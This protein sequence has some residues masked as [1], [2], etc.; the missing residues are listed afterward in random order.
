M[1][2]ITQRSYW[3]IFRYLSYCRLCCVLTS[4]SHTFTTVSSSVLLCHTISCPPPPPF[5][6]TWWT[7]RTSWSTWPGC[8]TS[9]Y[10][11]QASMSW[12]RGKSPSLTPSSSPP[13]P[14]WSTPHMSLCPSTYAWHWSFS[15][16]FA[17]ASLRA[18]WHSWTKRKRIWRKGGK[19]AATGRICP[20]IL[21]YNSTP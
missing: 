18:P 19:E 14:W 1:T 10:S 16:G 12:S 21:S 20:Q 9:T 4:V 3:I 17:V 8:T 11:S 13:S 2:Q 5:Q 15:L 6:P 7:S